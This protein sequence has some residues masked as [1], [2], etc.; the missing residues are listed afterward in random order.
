MFGHASV[1][2][3]GVLIVLGL[4][5]TLFP[6]CDFATG[7]G[8]PAKA[9]VDRELEGYWVATEHL[10]V[11]VAKAQKDGKT[12][13]FCCPPCVDEFVRMAKETPDQIKAPEMYVK[14]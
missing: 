13:E 14:K 7:V 10:Q 4:S 5:L 9:K 1:N 12:Y 2:R 6:A 11:L 3:V 8:D